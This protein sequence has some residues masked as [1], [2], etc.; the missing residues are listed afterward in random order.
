MPVNIT[1][2]R[3]SAFL[4]ITI[5]TLL[6]LFCISS[7]KARGFK[8]FFN[9]DVYVVINNSSEKLQNIFTLIEKQTPFSFA[10]DENDIN[11]SKEIKLATG[12]QLLKIILKEIETQAGLRFTEKANLILVNVK[13]SGIKKAVMTIPV[14]GVVRDLS[15]APLSSVTVLIKGTKVAVQTDADGK[16][17]IDAPDNGVLIFSRVDFKTQEVSI[18]GQAVL[19][20]DMV[21]V[22]KDLGEVVVVGYQSR[23]RGDLSGALSVVN[24][25]D[26]A[27]LPVLSVDQALQ[28]KV[29]GVRITQNT[30]Q[31]GDGVVVR[32]RG[33]GTI[34]DNNPLFIVD[35]IPTKD[36][37]NFLSPNDIESIVVLKDASSAAI[38]GSRAANG[39]VLITTKSGKKGKPQFNYSG[40]GGFQSHGDLPK[41]ANTAEY[42]ELYNE[43]ADNDNA[44][45][46]NPAL[47]RPKIPA[48]FPMA[49]TDWLREIFQ[50]GQIQS[51]QLSVRGGNDKTLY[52]I[53]GNYFKQNGIILNSSYERYSL[54]SK[55]N[56]ELT[57]KL[58]IAN[59]INVSYS[60]KN[61]IGG[62]GDGYGG[63]GGSV[64]RYALFR[65]PAIPVYDSAGIYSDLPAYPAFFGDGYNPVALANK[66]DNKEIQYRVFTNL[67]AEYKILKNLKF[68]SDI[69]LDAIITND[70]RF[71]E[72]YGTFLR[73][74]NPSRL[75]VSTSTN[76]NIIW[77]N[78]FG[79]NK[80]INSV[81]NISILAGTE[82]ISNKNNLHGGT[83]RSF[84]N[85]TA[86]FR[87]IGNGNG[88]IGATTA[89]EG[90]TESALFSL[91][92]NANYSYRNLYLFSANVRRDGSSRFGPD[93][94]Y[95][96]FFSGSLGWNAHNEKWVQDHLPVISKL[97]LRASYGQ[98]G[99]Q[100]IP[101]YGFVSIIGNL[102][103]YPFG[104]TQS[105]NPGSTIATLGNSK[106]KWESSTQADGG[107]DIGIWKDKL[108][109]TVDYFVKT[110]SDMLIPIPFPLI[111][112][113]AKPPYLNAGKVQNKGLEVDLN[114]KNNTHL[115]KYDIGVNF[116][117]LT[118]EVLS[119]S[120]GQ[121]IAGGRIDN[122]YNA[123][124]TT[125]GHP[126]GSFYL[127]EQ[128]G[129]FQNAADVFAHAY[130]G[131]G[132][133]PG[134][135]KFKDQNGDGVIDDKD[136]TFL[137]S[138]I[139]KYTFGATGN[140]EYRN[141]DLS[142]FF[143]GQYGNKIYSQVNMDI[144]GFY[145]AFNV[146]QRVFDERWHGEGTSNS[147][148]RVTF[149]GASNNKFPSSRFLEDGS[150]LRLKNCQIGY[151]IPEKIVSRY[152][153]KSLRFYVTG[154]NLWTLTNYTG[155]DPEMH[156]S[157]NVRR[158]TYGGDVGAGID[159]GTYPSARSFILGLN[160]N[161]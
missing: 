75:T 35:G 159:W 92:G 34:N 143:Q 56:I 120:N 44:G 26:I 1:Y 41:M 157:D 5:S 58:N 54:L 62:S 4:K 112:G 117:T 103:N 139:P 113:T 100:E 2:Y 60:K 78:T 53:S 48:T 42:V 71:D 152:K 17:S 25:G 136:R 79:Y 141:F 134:D 73:I 37:I 30:G 45:V 83:D 50:N 119:L 52:Y 16:F 74:N 97:K 91:F 123:T 127:Y 99:N 115:F 24:V 21:V 147:M 153:I 70:K 132:I 149:K 140:F 8:T 145:R 128:E 72:N 94:K 89:F 51:H 12:Q 160:L 126:I 67:Y 154:Q 111:G 61:M 125:V 107:I 158:D 102:Y 144:E 96:T 6:I 137:G 46:I 76:I 65:T 135:V 23:R 13:L 108:T 138:A 124:L 81:H 161:F 33:V 68:K 87:Y 86:R 15:G 150:Y 28:G 11:L 14:K 9:K 131:S 130:Q 69:G 98:L 38:Y 32:I 64:V 66:T 84:A 116:S 18:N 151:T 101:D 55:L 129:I 39:V 63:N 19:N 109:L 146:T 110:T 93:N 80:T 121:P 156:I 43:A 104:Q 22:N 85:Q 77:N 155:L 142:I 29:P 133:K 106:V 88:L 122:N 105:S 10:Y 27:K 118:N 95:G 82:A 3:T 31:P 40:Y 47:I 20:I 36:G 90:K 114:Y 7:L 148:P 57:D 49:N 59:N